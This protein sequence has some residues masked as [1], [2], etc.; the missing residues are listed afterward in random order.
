MRFFARSSFESC[1]ARSLRG[2][3]GFSM[4]EL[5]IVISILGIL[6]GLAVSGYGNLLESSKAVLAR[7]RVEALNQ[8]VYRF[9]E[10]NFE[11]TFPR[12][13]GSAVD[14]TAVLQMLQYENPEPENPA[15]QRSMTSAPYYD[16]RYRPVATSDTDT[17]RIRW[18]GRMYDLIP[19]GST[20]TGLL[21]NFDGSDF[22]T[23]YTYPESYRMSGR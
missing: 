10:E 23:P 7:E 8:S 19:N 5:V 20:G 14:E 3:G 11:Q 1:Y 17:Y 9:A 12:M 15:R 4:S 21:M 22:T 13:D 2:R 6:S 16:P 18:N